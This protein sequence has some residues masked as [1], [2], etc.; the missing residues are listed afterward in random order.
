MKN[1]QEKSTN[2]LETPN[3]IKEC[4]IISN[5]FK[6]LLM[7]LLMNQALPQDS[8]AN[9]SESQISAISKSYNQDIISDKSTNIMSVIS[10][11]KSEISDLYIKIWIAEDIIDKLSEQKDQNEEKIEIIKKEAEWLINELEDKKKEL[12]KQLEKLDFINLE[13][14]ILQKN[15]E[16]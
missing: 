12:S 1:F 2:L 11:L 7:W 15:K 3:T 13:N 14:Q 4:S 5:T 6:T 9:I 8:Y 10:D 16:L